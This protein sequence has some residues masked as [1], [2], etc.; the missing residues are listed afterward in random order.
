MKVCRAER[1]T[2]DDED[3]FKVSSS[4]PSAQLCLPSKFEI[5][6]RRACECVQLVSAQ[7]L[8]ISDHK[9]FPL[10][11]PPPLFFFR[12]VFR[13]R[14]FPNEKQMVESD[15]FFYW[16]TKLIEEVLNPWLIDQDFDLNQ[17]RLIQFVNIDQHREKRNACEVCI[18]YI[19]VYGEGLSISWG[20]VQTGKI[21]TYYTVK[22]ISNE[23][24]DPFGDFCGRPHGTNL[25]V[26]YD[27]DRVLWIM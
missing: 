22:S 4:C 14:E 27:S 3:G 24:S 6:E 8:P 21:R 13:H 10:P 16:L 7:P 5:R 26:S 23:M 17:S 15:F 25:N 9:L 12:I 1:Q 2:L 11:T 19:C 20:T 18:L